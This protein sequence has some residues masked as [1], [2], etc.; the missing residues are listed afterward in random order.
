MPQHPLHEVALK[1]TELLAPLNRA[2][3]GKSARCSIGSPQVWHLRIAALTR[4]LATAV[5]EAIASDSKPRITLENG[6]F[7]SFEMMKFR[8]RKTTGVRPT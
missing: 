1:A 7:R 8:D 2:V 5:M 3:S 6:T 4:E